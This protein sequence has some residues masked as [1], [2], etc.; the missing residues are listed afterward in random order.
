MNGCLLTVREVWYSISVISYPL[1]ADYFSLFYNSGVVFLKHVHFI[2]LLGFHI[3]VRSFPLCYKNQCQMF[4]VVTLVKP[5]S[6]I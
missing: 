4:I 2:C 5:P 6:G 3:F 1:K